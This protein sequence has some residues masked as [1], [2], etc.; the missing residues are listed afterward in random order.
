MAMVLR[1]VNSLGLVKKLFIR[2]VH[3]KDITSL[4]LK[5]A[6]DLVFTNINLIRGKGYDGASNMWGAYGLKALILKDNPSQ[7]NHD[8]V[9]DFF[10]QLTLV[11]NV[12]IKVLKY[13]EDK[14]SCLNNRN[15]MYVIWSYFKTL[16]FVYYLHLM[17][18]IFGLTN[19]LSKHL[20]RKDQNILEAASLVK[21]T[22]KMFKAFRNNGFRSMLEKIFSFCHTH[23]IKI[24]EM[25]EFY[26]TPRNRRTK[27][28]NQHHFDVDIFNT[29]LNMQI[30][31]VG[32]RFSEVSSDV[33]EY[34]AT[35]SPC[36]AF[37]MFNKSKLVKLSKSDKTDFNDSERVY[38]DGQLETC[39]HSLIDDERFYNLK[40]IADLS[41]LM[42]ETG[43]HLS[44]P[45]SLCNTFLLA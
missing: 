19:T 39:Y 24:V 36:N 13:V 33:L 12:V 16:D 17:L 20:Q 35:L 26:V 22:I 27:V 34:M 44:F 32:D 21:V 11:V 7:K 3:G 40:G 14:R 2:I 6:I 10:E 9:D 37:S 15:Q 4:T 30:Q 23:K 8:G 29:I 25:S 42:V 1:Y 41:R 5:K 31:E 45:L 18:E 38:L 43:K 28:T